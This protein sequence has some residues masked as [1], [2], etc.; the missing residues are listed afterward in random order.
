MRKRASCLCGC[1]AQLRLKKR[2]DGKYKGGKKGLVVECKNYRHGLNE[3]IGDRDA[4][5]VVDK[6]LSREEYFEDFYVEYKQDKNTK[7]LVGLFWQANMVK[8]LA[9]KM[10]HFPRK[11]LQRRCSK[12][13]YHDSQLNMLV[14]LLLYQLNK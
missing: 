1:T 11:Y 7:A 3:F 2:P 14:K 4:Q 10:F 12:Y 5:M 8:V 9:T 6:L 13:A